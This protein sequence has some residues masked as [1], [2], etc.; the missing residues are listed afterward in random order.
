MMSERF[1]SKN[2]IVFLK[3]K[4]LKWK[5]VEYRNYFPGIS[6]LSILIYMINIMYPE[7]VDI[8]NL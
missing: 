8:C 7:I 4:L 1:D 6:F 3:S 2:I 5:Y